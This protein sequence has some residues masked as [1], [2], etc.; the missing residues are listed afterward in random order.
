M[1]DQ[2]PRHPAACPRNV[3]KGSQRS[4]SQ[5]SP[6]IL[7]RP[8]QG[9]TWALEADYFP[10]LVQTA[11]AERFSSPISRLSWHGR[12]ARSAWAKRPCHDSPNKHRLASCRRDAFFGREYSLEIQRICGND[13]DGFSIPFTAESAEQ[14][15][16]LRQRKLLTR[17]SSDE[18]AAANFAS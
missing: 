10:A 3:E 15:H 12:L 16:R 17:E 11:K 2:P 8:G 1:G 5:Y 18:S 14:F 9:M 7:D 13:G 4:E 6:P